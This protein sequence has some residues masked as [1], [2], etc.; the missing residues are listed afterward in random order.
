MY[1]LV[2]EN[3]YE[4][5]EKLNYFKEK[6]TPITEEEIIRQAVRDNSQQILDGYLEGPYWKASW[7]TEDTTLAFFDIMN[8][9][10]GTIDSLSGSFIEDFRNSAPNLIRRLA[11]K[12]QKIVN[13]H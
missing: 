1:S 8:N 4:V 7:K 3:M 6:G 12:I 9:E 2:P 5:E 13:T 11:E 10:V